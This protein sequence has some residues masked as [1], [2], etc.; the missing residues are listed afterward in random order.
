MRK[1]TSIKEVHS[2]LI[3]IAKE[4]HNICVRHN[5]PYYML[6]GTMLGAV[7]HKGFIPWDDDM[8]F[9]IP[10]EYYEQFT[11]YAIK[12]LP[13]PY[14]IQTLDNSNYI[15]YG[16]NKITNTRTI[17]SEFHK[18]NTNEK[19]GINIDIFPL[20]KIDCRIGLFSRYWFFRK[21]IKL[22]GILFIDA[23]NKSTLKKC[24]IYPLKSILTFKKNTIPSLINKQIYHNKSK[25]NKIA[26][27]YGAWGV[28][29]IINS[30]IMGTPQLYK[31]EDTELYGVADYDKYLKSLYN[32][33]MQIPPENKRRI[34]SQD[35][36]IQIS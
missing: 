19:I 36:Y 31:F 28:K 23:K 16:F 9:G 13:E 25:G 22:Q 2:I 4:F 29:E 33:Y 24:M 11:K 7:R 17:I 18:S 8:D 20:D 14:R 5:I 12:E 35:F 30:E 3:S 34:H 32:N 1:I 27:I 21:L 26:N 10:R 6:G 15:I